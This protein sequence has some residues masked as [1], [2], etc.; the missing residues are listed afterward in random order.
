M[1][2]EI[3]TPQAH[4]DNAGTSG[5]AQKCIALVCTAHAELSMLHSTARFS[6]RWQRPSTKGR[7][8]IVLNT[9]DLYIIQS[10]VYAI[11][12]D[13]G[14]CRKSC[15]DLL[16]CLPSLSPLSVLQLHQKNRAGILHK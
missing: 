9:S 3:K 5:G 2:N 11:S 12:P 6:E 7:D 16:C 15:S 8:T 4:S 10:V 14:E 1:Q 13:I